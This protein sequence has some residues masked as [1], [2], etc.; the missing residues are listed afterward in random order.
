M[1]WTQHNKYASIADVMTL[2]RFEVLK[3]Y[4][5]ANDNTHMPKKGTADYDHLYKVRPIVQSILDMC[6]LV[7][8]EECQFNDE[9][10][11]STKSRCPIRQYLSKKPH[12]WGI[13]VWARC[14]VSRLPYDFTVH[15]GKKNTD[16]SK[17]YGKVGAVV[18]KLV[19]HLLKNIE[20]KIFMDNLFTS[21]KL[22]ITL[23]DLGIWAVGTIRNT[24]PHGAKNAMSKKE[25]LEKMGHGS[26]KYRLD[27]NYNITVIR[28][29]LNGVI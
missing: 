22:F 12:K 27:F 14:G 4:F 10:I 29:M 9:Q 3:K 11:I 2:K 18:L 23:K 21:I 15:L 24:R 8:Q 13:K 17:E 1:Y 16:I 19:T 7:E 6:R 26:L 28:W 20:H 25:E 5:H